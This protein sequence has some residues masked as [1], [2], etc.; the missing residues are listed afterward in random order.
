[1]ALRTEDNY[2][3][4]FGSKDTNLLIHTHFV[5]Q[6]KIEVDGRINQ[7]LVVRRAECVP[8]HRIAPV[9]VPLAQ[10]TESFDSKDAL[11][12]VVLLEVIT[13][14]TRQGCPHLQLQ[15]R[16]PCLT[17]RFDAVPSLIMLYVRA[18]HICLREELSKCQK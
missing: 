12:R 16:S 7:E 5:L 17:T 2:L 1:Y 15:C 3:N 6:V 9:R 4:F 13:P 11:L 10:N 18:G 8:E 14:M